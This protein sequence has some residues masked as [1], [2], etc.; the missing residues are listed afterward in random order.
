MSVDLDTYRARVG[1]GGEFAPTVE[2][3]KALHLAHPT[4]IPFENLDVLLRRPIRLDLE[5]LWGKLVTGG[6]G[7]YCF[8]HNAVF[9]AVLEASGFRVRRLAARVRYGTSGVRP[10]LHM[11]LL[12]EAEGSPWLADVGFGADGLLQ[13]IPFRTDQEAPQFAWKY[14]LVAEAP[15]YVLQ[16]WEPAG[17]LDLYAFGLEEHYP[18]DFEVANYYTSMHPES[19]FRRRLTAQLPGPERRVMLVNRTL[20]EQTPEGVVEIPV[21]DDEALLGVLAERFGLVFPAGTRFPVDGEPRL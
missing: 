10:R 13:P 16:S 8:E 3:L 20:S 12:V 11:L 4:R 1:Y 14:R 6:R 19:R 15:N 5:S 9:A 2:T 7:G 18:I 21:G 17:W